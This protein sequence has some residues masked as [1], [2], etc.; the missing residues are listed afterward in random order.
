MKEELFT[1]PVKR[2]EVQFMYRHYQRGQMV[3]EKQLD[4]FKGPVA[5]VDEEEKKK[6]QMFYDEMTRLVQT[7]KDQL[8]QGQQDFLKLDMMRSE[9]LEALDLNPYAT[10]E[11]RKRLDDLPKEE[12]YSITF[13]RNSAKFTLDLIEKEL[14]KLKMVT[15]PGYEK[16]PETDFPDVIQSKVFWINKANKAKTILENFKIKIEKEL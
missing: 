10:V 5:S 7:L 16:R 4:K 1:I 2:E 8:M 13:D 15:I 12:P 6:A 14:T 11:I 3:A 9:L